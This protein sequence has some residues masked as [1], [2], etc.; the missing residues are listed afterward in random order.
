MED[1]LLK[2][3]KLLIHLLYKQIRII[4]TF[5]RNIMC[6]VIIHFIITRMFTSID[7][8]YIYFFISNIIWKINK[9]ACISFI[10][11]TT[12]V[13]LSFLQKYALLISG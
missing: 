4:S 13:Q 1:L 3:Q 12:L 11:Y 5:K 2:V 10:I 9:F 7:N 8:I 6:F